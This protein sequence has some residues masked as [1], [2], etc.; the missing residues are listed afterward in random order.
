[1]TRTRGRDLSR[2]PIVCWGSERRGPARPAFPPAS[3]PPPRRRQR[4][5]RPRDRP[6]NR[7]ERLLDRGLHAGSDHDPHVSL[8]PPHAARGR[9]RSPAALHHAPHPGVDRVSVPRGQDLSSVLRRGLKVRVRS[10][11]AGSLRARLFLDRRTALR[12]RLRR[13]FASGARDSGPGHED[14]APA[15][16]QKTPSRL[17]ATQARAPYSGAPRQGKGDDPRT[18]QTAHRRRREGIAQAL[19]PCGIAA[20]RFGLCSSNGQYRAL[21]RD[22]AAELPVAS[23]AGVGEVRSN[24]ASSVRRTWVTPACPSRARP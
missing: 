22:A 7:G 16:D 6:P 2:N 11:R 12:H 9:D 23:V 19:A 15:G 20:L 14:R 8:E 10:P 5:S 1:M 24:S 21:A 3:A 13:L 18:H 17:R 4:P